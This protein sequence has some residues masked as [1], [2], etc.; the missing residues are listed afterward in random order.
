MMTRGRPGGRAF[1]AG[2]KLAEDARSSGWIW[3]RCVGLVSVT[4]LTSTERNLLDRW[5]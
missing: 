5:F 2:V 4:Y 1:K 3:P